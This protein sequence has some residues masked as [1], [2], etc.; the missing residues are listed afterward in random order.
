MHHHGKI[1]APGLIISNL[2]SAL[3]LLVDRYTSYWKT[4]SDASSQ[5]SP[6]RRVKRRKTTAP[7]KKKA[8]TTRIKAAPGP[9]IPSSLP[10]DIDALF[11]VMDYLP[12]RELL[13]LTLCSKELVANLTVAKVVKSALTQGGLPAKTIRHLL[14]MYK[15]QS[16]YPDSPLRLLRLVNGR[17]CELCLKAHS[18]FLPGVPVFYC[19]EC[20]FPEDYLS[21]SRCTDPKPD[22]IVDDESCFYN[23]YVY[24]RPCPTTGNENF[25]K[26]S[27]VAVFTHGGE[28]V[29]FLANRRLEVTMNVLGKTER[30]GPLVVF[31]DIAKMDAMSR[32]GKFGSLTFGFWDT[33]ATFLRNA[34]PDLPDDD[35]YAE[36]VKACKMFGHGRRDLG[37]KK[38]PD[39]LK[40]NT[41]NNRLEKVENMV[42]KLWGGFLPKC[43]GVIDVLLRYKKTGWEGN[44]MPCVRFE[45]FIIDEWLSEYIIR[46]GKFNIYVRAEV[47]PGLQLLGSRLEHMRTGSFLSDTDAFDVRVKLELQ[48]NKTS[49]SSMLD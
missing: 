15:N 39:A 47:T 32:E 27:R 3:L 10:V 7:A 43:R 9:A 30:W 8:R 44:N 35:D 17:R 36:F 34:Y 23:P 19:E 31:D 4:M 16:I 37:Q 13:S 5:G 22:Y 1:N 33:F 24:A 6:E 26:E 25:L 20:F 28:K 21:W 29:P 45:C 11:L 41:N 38:K 46:P 42:S 18:R 48:Q 12:P 40:A 14:P 2:E 49:A